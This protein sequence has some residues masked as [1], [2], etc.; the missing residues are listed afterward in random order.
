MLRLICDT[1]LLI[2][3]TCMFR[4]VE[5]PDSSSVQSHKIQS[6]AVEQ[7]SAPVVQ[8]STSNVQYNVNFLLQEDG[9]KLAKNAKRQ[10]ESQ[11]RVNVGRCFLDNN[12]TR[13]NAGM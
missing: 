9:Q 6:T 2:M 8:Q 1:A 12:C 11:V 5:S 4:S 10:F 3:R 13:L 7:T